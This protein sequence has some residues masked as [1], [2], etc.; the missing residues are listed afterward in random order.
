M[1][2]TIVEM[3]AWYGGVT[4]AMQYVVEPLAHVWAWHKTTRGQLDYAPFNW[5]V[6][7]GPKR[8]FGWLAG[9][10]GLIRR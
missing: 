4:I 7:C 3:L 9:F 5:R 6:L 8:Y 2:K 1:T 10:W